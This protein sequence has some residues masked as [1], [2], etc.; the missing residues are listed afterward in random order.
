[1][2]LALVAI[3][4]A[5]TGVQPA[6]AA[7]GRSLRALCLRRKLHQA[8]LL[9]TPDEPEPCGGRRRALV[10]F[11]QNQN[12]DQ[13][14]QQQQQDQQNQQQQQDQLNGGRSRRAL[15][16]N[17]DEEDALAAGYAL[18]APAPSEREETN[19]ML[20][21][22]MSIDPKTHEVKANKAYATGGAVGGSSLGP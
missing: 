3:C 17:E 16:Q 6:D 8:P 9:T 22:G 19:R 11:W 15:K 4:V 20:Y 18:N 21:A 7:G 2:A 5:S 1:L 13:Q 14:Q 10:W 12:Q